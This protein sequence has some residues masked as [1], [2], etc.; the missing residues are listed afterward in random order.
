MSMDTTDFQVRYYD[1]ELGEERS[2][3]E[4]SSGALDFAYGTPVGRL[5]LKVMASSGPSAVWGSLMR[6]PVSRGRI[7]RFCCKNGITNASLVRDGFAPMD[8]YVSYAD[9][10]ART[11][12]VTC[13]G[14]PGTLYAPVD[15]YLLARRINEGFSV[16]VKGTTYTI[17]QLLGRADP[18]YQEELRGGHCL[19]FRLSLTDYHHFHYPAAGR[20]VAQYQVPGTLHSVR[21]VAA[22]KR[23]YSTNKRSVSVLSLNAFGLAMMVEVGAMLVGQI[24]QDK[25][26]ETAQFAAGQHKGQFLLGGS[27][28]VLLVGNTV[29][30]DDDIARASARGIEA[31]VRAGTRIGVQA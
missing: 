4:P 27:T 11:R 5:L 3:I 12:L 30:M 29:D 6:L 1:R 2:T 10:F 20:L 25:L 19:V 8:A 23:P 24:V 17:P 16:D 18:L 9:F 14:A 13:D 7:R 22:G 28:V 21:P 26:G 15:G 31:R